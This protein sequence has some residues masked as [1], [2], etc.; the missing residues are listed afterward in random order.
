MSFSSLRGVTPY[1]LRRLVQ[2]AII[3]IA[4]SILSFLGLALAPGDPTQ[5]ILGQTWTPERANVLRATLGL[6]KPLEVR[7][8]NWLSGAIHGDLGRSYT[9]NEPVSVVVL[10]AIPISLQLALASLLISL[11]VG[12]IMGI[13][14][15][16]KR[17]SALDYLSRI[18]V[19]CMSS[20]P[21]FWLGLIIIYIFA[22]KLPIFPTGGLTSA[23][24]IVLPAAC[25]SCYSLAGSV[26]MMRSAMLETL[27]RDYIRTVRAYGF[28]ER[29]VI[30]RHALRNVM[31]PVVTMSGLYLGAL[32]GSSI[33]TENVF[34]WPGLGTM[35]ISAVFTRDTPVVLGG[36][37]AVAVFY[38]MIN[39]CLDILY[40]YL[41]PR[42]QLR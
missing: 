28:S 35:I 37:L 42:I 21:I 19:V 7:Y 40:V 41:D 17:G 22:V 4:L 3:I 29:V 18:F 12:S 5:T 24:S 13:F 27:P 10:R 15:A 23:S 25:L 26:R 33:I 36:V 32:I 16:I 1:I 11:S 38:S 14:S 6:D 39:L 20:M 34:A 31:I 2:S 8:I 30:F 9:T